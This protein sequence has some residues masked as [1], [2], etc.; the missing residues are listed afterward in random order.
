MLLGITPTEQI[1]E[2]ARVE[3]T[4]AV[5]NEEMAVTLSSAALI[6]DERVKVQIELDT[7]MSRLGFLSETAHLSNSVVAICRISTFRG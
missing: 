7:G 4:Q 6:L 1:E 5:Y 3:F 2:L